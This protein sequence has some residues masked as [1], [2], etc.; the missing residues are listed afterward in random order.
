MLQKISAADARTKFSDLLGRVKYGEED[1]LIEKRGKPFAV[2][3][4]LDDY[5]KIKQIKK[6]LLSQIK[7]TWVKTKDI[8]YS[9]VKK[10]VSQA[11]AAVREE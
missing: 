11:I 3:V 7:Q 6:L 1:I 10:D 5:M 9:Q 2:L 4:N 8:P